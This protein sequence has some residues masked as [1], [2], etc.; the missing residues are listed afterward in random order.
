MKKFL[1]A[2]SMLGLVSSA[3]AASLIDAS[4]S[5][6]VNKG[7]GFVPA[8]G[9]VKLNAG[10]KVLVGDGGFASVS[11][12]KCTVSLDKPTVHAVTK[13]A[14][15]DQ[16][17]I[18]PVADMDAPMAAGFAGLPLPL[19]LIGGVAAIGTGVVIYNVLDDEDD[20]VSC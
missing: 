7:K 18:S 3:N 11:Y 13:T 17:V 5:V 20:C 6:M 8:V 16:P 4:G 15:C 19:L 12:G 9:N 1:I 2:V 10:D 14:P